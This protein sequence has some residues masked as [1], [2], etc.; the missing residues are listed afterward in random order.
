[1]LKLKNEIEEMRNNK[2]YLNDYKK[3]S[4]PDYWKENDISQELNIED[5][6]IGRDGTDLY[7]SIYYNIDDIYS[8]MA[9]FKAL[10]NKTILDALDSAIDV[11]DYEEVTLFGIG[12]DE[13][14]ALSGFCINISLYK[15]NGKYDNIRDANIAITLSNEYGGIDIAHQ[16]IEDEYLKEKLISITKEIIQ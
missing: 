6:V 2:K 9:I 12:T 8:G 1:M 10:T 14:A 3:K 11:A 13:E 7:R 4:N 16:D 15:N 5:M